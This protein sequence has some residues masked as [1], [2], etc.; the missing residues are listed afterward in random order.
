MA[1]PSRHRLWRT[2]RHPGTGPVSDATVKFIGKQRGY[3][4]L[5]LLEHAKPYS[6]AYGHLSRFGAGLRKGSR[7]TQGQVIGYVGMTGLATG[8][9]LHYEFRVKDIQQNPLAMKLPS[10]YPLDKRSRA[11]FLASSAPLMHR[12]N[13]VRGHKLTALD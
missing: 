10:A 11:K 1:R 4:N 5:V 6:T 9:H 12:L 13:M 7:V 8:P 3:G 2:D